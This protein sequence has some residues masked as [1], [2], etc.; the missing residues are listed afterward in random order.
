MRYQVEPDA[1]IGDSGDAGHHAAAVHVAGID[2]GGT[3]TSLALADGSGHELL[4]RT[5]TAGLIDPT[6]PRSTA[7]KLVRLIRR[8]AADAGIRLPLTSACAGLAGAGTAAVRR[9]VRSALLEESIADRVSILG[10]GEIAFEGAFGRR[11]GI[12]LVAGTGSGAYGRADTGRIERCGGWGT[13]LGDEGSGYAVAREGLRSALHAADGRGPATALLGELLGAVGAAA[14][15]ELT[16][17]AESVDK[18]RIAALA[19]RVVALAENGDDVADRIIDAAA[20]D[21][22]RHV[23]ALVE[24]L[25]PW[26]VPLPV[27]FHGGLFREKAVAGRVERRLGSASIPLTRSEPAADAVAGA[28]RLALGL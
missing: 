19:P 5:A 9:L 15:P 12:L 13:R 28:I 7:N 21:L 26:P 2:G 24:R 11:R 17:W 1:P 8:A 27:V 22:M 10:D 6:D 18:G 25:A 23:H 20:D 4:R 16:E 14:A 3:R